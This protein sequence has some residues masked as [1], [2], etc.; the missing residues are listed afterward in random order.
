MLKER[1]K[2]LDCNLASVKKELAE[3]KVDNTSF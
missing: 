3:I 1:E 2:A